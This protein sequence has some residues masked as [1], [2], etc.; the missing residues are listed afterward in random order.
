MV[1]IK[2]T[3]SFFDEEMKKAGVDIRPAVPRH[4]EKFQNG[5]RY[6][7]HYA[8]KETGVIVCSVLNFGTFVKLCIRHEDE[9]K[10][11]VQTF[12]NEDEAYEKLFR[13]IFPSGTE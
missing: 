13:T 7:L 6:Y 11:V 2:M 1:Q 5:T 3:R 12:E 8:K 9:Q 4:W 10:D